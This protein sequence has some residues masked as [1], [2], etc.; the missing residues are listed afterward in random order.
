MIS[1][2]HGT[3]APTAPGRLGQPLVAQDALRYLEA[4][5]TWR[6]ERKAE[7]DVLDRHLAD[8]EYLAGNEYTIADM[9]VWPWYGALAKG[10]LYEAGKFLSVQTRRQAGG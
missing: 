4:L 5:G 1:V 8:C 2:T 6:D 3:T 10:L 9:A 7:L